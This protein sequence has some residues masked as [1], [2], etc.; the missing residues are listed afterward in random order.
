MNLI[1]K[2]LHCTNRKNLDTD[3][4]F[5]IDEIELLKKIPNWFQMIFLFFF[6]S[7]FPNGWMPNAVKIILVPITAIKTR[8]MSY[9]DDLNQIKYLE[10][11]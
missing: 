9:F 11:K 3:N 2:I 10:I 5:E 6:Y 7:Q 8:R 1:R 4:I